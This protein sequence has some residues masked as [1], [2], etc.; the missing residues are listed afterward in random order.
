M[1]G[2]NAAQLIKFAFIALAI[3]AFAQ[4]RLNKTEKIVT[5]EKNGRPT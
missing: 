1:S 5:A 3:K 4:F 2:E